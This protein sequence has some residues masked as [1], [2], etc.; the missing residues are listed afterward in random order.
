MDRQLHYE[1]YCI[2]M[3]TEKMVIKKTLK[4]I[5]NFEKKNFTFMMIT[6]LHNKL[7]HQELFINLV[8]VL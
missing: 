2:S 6:G 5:Q 7:H 4:K 1:I 3:V 8:T